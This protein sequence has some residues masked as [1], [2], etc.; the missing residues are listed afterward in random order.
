MGGHLHGAAHFLDH[1]VR[2]VQAG[3][4]GL[5]RGAQPEIQLRQGQFALLHVGQN[6]PLP[7]QL[8][9]QPQR[10]QGTMR[11]AMQAFLQK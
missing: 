2:H 6:D 1:F 4:A 10:Q 3:L 8:F 5:L 9:G 7:Q 11:A